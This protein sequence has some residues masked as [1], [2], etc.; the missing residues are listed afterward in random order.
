MGLEGEK[1]EFA[2]SADVAAMVRSTESVLAN[3]VVDDVRLDLRNGIAAFPEPVQDHACRVLASNGLVQSI[4]EP[5]HMSPPPPRMNHVLSSLLE[6][7]VTDV[8]RRTVESDVAQRR[9]LSESTLRLLA[10]LVLRGGDGNLVVKTILAAD[11]EMRTY[12][13]RAVLSSMGAKWTGHQ[14][15]VPPGTNLEPFAWFLPQ[16][17]GPWA[18]Y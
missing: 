9:P 5:L 7:A 6:T 18:Q 2:V 1:R 12:Q 15:V 16:A 10:R 8:L 14:W 13:G 4:G 11:R 3:G 17:T